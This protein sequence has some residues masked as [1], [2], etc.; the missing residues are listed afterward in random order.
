VL[1]VVPAASIGTDVV[2]DA[3]SWHFKVVKM[4]F[5]DTIWEVAKRLGHRGRTPRSRPVQGA[6]SER[7]E[8]IALDQAKP[9]TV[10]VNKATL[11]AALNALVAAHGA[12]WWAIDGPSPQGLVRLTMGGSGWSQSWIGAP[13][14]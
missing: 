8:A 5:R 3:G 14:R 1:N 4:P 10:D 2:L 9:V 6:L 13:N 11:R 12:A 7:V